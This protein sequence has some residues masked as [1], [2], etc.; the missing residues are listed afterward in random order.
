M[1]LRPPV[2]K[3][4]A[5]LSKNYTAEKYSVLEKVDKGIDIEKCFF[6]E[7]IEKKLERGVF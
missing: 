7:E 3:V 6:T 4:Y 5:V 1:L 2:Q